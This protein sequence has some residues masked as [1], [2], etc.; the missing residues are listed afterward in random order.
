MVHP[1]NRY[2]W[3]P[4]GV[5]PDAHGELLLRWDDSV[6]MFCRSAQFKMKQSEDHSNLKVS[7]KGTGG[8]LQ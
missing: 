7:R 8:N 5:E 3:F 1:F 6:L 4:P 2:A